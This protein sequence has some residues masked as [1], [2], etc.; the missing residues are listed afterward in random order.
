MAVPHQIGDRH[1]N[2]SSAA[3]GLNQLKIHNGHV[4]GATAALFV[5]LAI[6]LAKAVAPL[7]VVGG[8]VILVLEVWRRRKIP[9]FTT[10][11]TLFMGAFALWALVSWF[12]SINPDETLKTGISFAATLFGGAVLVFAAAGLDGKQKKVFQDGLIA[13]GA[14]GFSLIAVEFATDAWVS[15]FIYGLAGKMLFFVSDGYIAVLNAGLAASALFFWPW[16]LAV[17]GRYAKWPA[18]IGIAAA[19]GLFFLSQADAVIVGLLLGAGVFTLTIFL[20]RLVPRLVTV[21]VPGG[22]AVVVAGGVLLAP[23]MPGLFPDPQKPDNIL[24][25]LPNSA[26]HR[27]AIWR[28]AAGHIKEKPFLGG[29]FDS[30]RSLYGVKDKVKIVYFAG[31]GKKASS[32]MYEPIPLH[33]HNGMLQVWMEMGAVGALILL[34]VLLSVILAAHRRITHNRDRAATWAMMSVW[35]C[36]SSL[37]FGAWQSWWLASILLAAAFMVCQLAPFRRATAAPLDPPEIEIGGP[38]G[39][40]PTRYGDWERKGRAIDF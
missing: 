17:W 22:L 39:P 10:W 6:F 18:G 38:Q 30:T 8:L 7:F 25:R 26:I 5:P 36:I 15:R 40:E 23:L 11:V 29:G 20:S 13:G 32:A 28:T 37:S 12:W 33:P 19:F 27:I 14:V 34:G 16:A 2:Y 1:V 4:L 21:L 31:N 35:I 9:V 3:N 24:T